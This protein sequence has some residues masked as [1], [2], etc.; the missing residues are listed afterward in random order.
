MFGLTVSHTEGHAMSDIGASRLPEVLAAGRI[1]LG[2]ASLLAPRGFARA[3]GVAEPSAELAY[4]T[5]IYGARAIAMGAGYLTSQPLE[6]RRWKR[7]SLAVD[8]S[9]TVTGLAH[10][11]RRDAPVRAIGSM[12]ALTGGYAAVG[13]AHLTGER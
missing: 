3:V 1:A 6:R 5:R 10:L 9:D 4:L 13:A 11:V 12:V 2:I 7:L 8:I